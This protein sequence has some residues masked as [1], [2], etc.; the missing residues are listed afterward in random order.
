[1]ARAFDGPRHGLGK[2]ER[3]LVHAVIGDPVGL[4]RRESAE[5]DVKGDFAGLDSPPAQPFEEFGG[6]MQSRGRGGDRP[7]FAGVDGLVAFPVFGTSLG[8]GDVG[9]KRH[10]AVTFRV[11][12]EA[13]ARGEFEVALTV[14]I[15]GSDPG[16]EAVGAVAEPEFGSGADAFGGAEEDPPTAFGRG[17]GF[18]EE[19]F[20]SPAA[21][22]FGGPEAGGDHPGVVHDQEVTGAKVAGEIRK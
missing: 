17:C 21:E 19:D 14:R 4:D 15:L 10:L 22:R 11:L 2:H 18:Q 7:W 3:L 16:R 12:E 6:E 5:A 8:T 1:M 13:G 20:D 9:R